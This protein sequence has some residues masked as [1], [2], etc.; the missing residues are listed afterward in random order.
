MWDIDRPLPP[1]SHLLIEEWVGSFCLA[2]PSKAG[3]ACGTLPS[4]YGGLTGRSTSC[5]SHRACVPW[6]APGGFAAKAD[7]LGANRR[8]EPSLQ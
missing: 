6:D 8:R 3:I 7:H 1:P 5:L 2:C 4:D